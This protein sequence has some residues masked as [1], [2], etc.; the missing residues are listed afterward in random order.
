MF[1]ARDQAK[2]RPKPSRLAALG[3]LFSTTGAGTSAAEGG[4]G[5]ADGIGSDVD[6]EDDNLSEISEKSGKL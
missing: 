2:K 5:E 3:R 1:S 4:G 6:D